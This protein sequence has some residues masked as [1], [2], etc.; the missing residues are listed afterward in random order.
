[1][2]HHHGAKS[3]AHSARVL[4]TSLNAHAPKEY[5]SL[6]RRLVHSV[7]VRS[8]KT[9]KMLSNIVEENIR[10]ESAEDLLTIKKIL[11]ND[12]VKEEAKI[13]SELEK[14][15][16]LTESSVDKALDNQKNLNECLEKVAIFA[17]AQR[18][19]DRKTHPG[20]LPYEGEINCLLEKLQEYGIDLPTNWKGRLQKYENPGLV[21]VRYEMMYEKIRRSGIAHAIRSEKYKKLHFKVRNFFLGLQKKVKLV[22]NSIKMDLIGFKNWMQRKISGGRFEAMTQSTHLSS[23]HLSVSNSIKQLKVRYKN[24]TLAFK[25]VAQEIEKAVQSADC[26]DPKDFYKK[27]A[28][29]S[30]QRIK[31]NANWVDPHSGL[32]LS[33]VTALVWAATKDQKAYQPSVD[34]TRDQK[35]RINAFVE[36][37]WRAHR[38]YNLD[39]F[40][41]DNLKKAV[42][43]CL[44]GTFN[45]IVES[46]DRIHPDV[47]IIRSAAIA[48]DLAAEL[49]KDFYENHPDQKSLYDAR[50]EDAAVRTPE[51]HDLIGAMNNYVREKLIEKMGKILKA[52]KIKGILD[53]LEYI[54]F[55]QPNNGQSLVQEYF[56]QKIEES[57]Q[58]SPDSEAAIAWAK[59]IDQDNDELLPFY[60]KANSLDTL[61]ALLTKL[62]AGNKLN[63]VDD[64]TLQRQQYNGALTD[65]EAIKAHI[66]QK[67][68]MYIK[69]IIVAHAQWGKS[70]K[71][72]V[73]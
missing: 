29:N 5:Q 64:M 42:P 51:Q 17:K 59:E 20:C 69:E 60:K 9:E 49:A 46:L 53:N 30:L 10:F 66:E 47:T 25:Q 50:L 24:E 62:K 22:A 54:D 40:G 16:R 2:F 13:L 4:A 65:I 19:T 6:V 8:R 27:E 36:H 45:K 68:E 11:V 31:K 63:A 26:K 44:G 3:F 37:L 57:K 15:L 32:T 43:A 35:D 71:P 61:N 33:E 1:M 21:L 56:S 55:P 48:N 39:E 7:L 14:E 72:T 34:P 38:E 52:D 23:V 28:L 12:I 73:S 58:F 67:K 18:E 70:N 41:A